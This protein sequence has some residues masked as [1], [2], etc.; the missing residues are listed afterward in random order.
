MIAEG[1]GGAPCKYYGIL[2]YDRHITSCTYKSSGYN[3]CSMFN[4]ACVK[5]SLCIRISPPVNHFATVNN[6]HAGYYGT[7]I[8]MMT[9]TRKL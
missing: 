3:S 1:G 9:P 4:Q 6:P 8:D 2:S 5:K 7:V